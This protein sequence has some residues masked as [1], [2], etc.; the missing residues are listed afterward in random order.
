MKA[1]CRRGCGRSRG[2]ALWLALSGR[3]V[4]GSAF[5][6][7]VSS[8]TAATNCGTVY[9]KGRGVYGALGQGD[10][11]DVQ[12]FLK[13]GPCGELPEYVAYSSVSAGWDHTAAVTSSGDLV[14][15]GMPF[16][17]AP[18]PKIR[19]RRPPK[20]HKP[21]AI[22]KSPVIHKSPVVYI[23]GHNI[24]QASC[25]SCFTLVLSAEGRVFAIGSNGWGQCGRPAEHKESLMLEPQAIPLPNPVVAVDTGLQNC[26]ALDNAGDVYCWGRGHSGQI[27]SD[28]D[29]EYVHNP[30]RVGTIKDI[31]AISAGFGHCA[32]VDVH[33]ALYVWGRG[34][35]AVLRR[36]REWVT[37]N[38]CISCHA[39]IS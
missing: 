37:Y 34:A 17:A 36:E 30:V 4:V 15:M 12:D 35:S 2:R 16:D 1:A 22:S 24:I 33:G 9:T 27:G 11:R 10:L 20:A 23:R 8:L 14:L 18:F 28:L 38:C 7:T 29:G 3:G 5:A 13:I 32:A 26:I 39:G 21:P 6:S 25:S 19:N 31:I